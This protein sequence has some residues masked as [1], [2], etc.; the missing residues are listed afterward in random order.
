MFPLKPFAIGNIT[1]DPPLIL[2]PMAGVSHSPL[3]QLVASF[4]RP[5]LFFSEMLSAKHIPDD[6]KKHSFWLAR[7]TCEQPMA[8]QIVAPSP[9]EAALGASHLCQIGAEIIDLNLACPAPNISGRR[10]AGGFLLS[11]LPL[12]TDIL[13]TLRPVV[14]CPLT[15]K[16][17][18]GVKPDLI[19]LHDLV[20]I[21]EATGVDAITL[22][23]R[24]T[25]EKLKRRA[26][27]E[28]IGHLKDMTRLPVI[29]NGDVVTREDCLTM[30]DQTGCDGVMIGRAAAQKP[31]LFAEITSGLDQE[32]TAEFLFATYQKAW[33][34]MTDFFPANQTL[35]RIKE[36][37]WYFTKNLR[38]GH[39]LAARM[40]NLPDLPACW[41]LVKE[42]FIKS[43]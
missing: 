30:F 6:I 21:L 32:I 18:L 25:T 2:A 7:E 43:W 16:I 42:E 11:D 19:F 13:S 14:S 10:K 37:T 31:W 29:G 27:W 5:G 39:R 34:M 33:T 22:H 17:R 36:F 1:I 26:R 41:Q 3:R 12:V 4:A 35:G 24:L 40:Q 28:Y 20:D 8:Y 23:P 9:E 15:V 38:F